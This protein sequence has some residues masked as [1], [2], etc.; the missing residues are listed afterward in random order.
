[1]TGR[2]DERGGGGAERPSGWRGRLGCLAAVVVPLTLVVGIAWAFL[3]PMG[4]VPGW[5][6]TTTWVAKSDAAEAAPEDAADRTWLAGD[7]VVRGRPDG[8]RAFHAGSGAKHWEYTPPRLTD[9][10]ALSATADDSVALIAYTA[11]DG[12]CA[13]V[14][15]LDLTDGRELWHASRAPALDAVTDQGLLPGQGPLTGRGFLGVGGALALADG[16]GLVLEGGDAPALRALELRTG[17]PRWTAAVPKGCEPGP[18]ATA[19]EQ[20]LTVL[21][22]GDER[23]LAA[24]APTDG[25]VRWTV[26]LDA[27]RGVSAGTAVSVVSAEP[28]VLRVDGRDFLA[29]G[30]DGR[31]GPRIEP[32]DAPS[33]L[34]GADVAVSDGRLFALTKGGRWG[35][36]V[37][38][39]LTSG[40]ELW[41]ANLGGAGYT[42]GGLYAGNGRVMALRTSAKSGNILHVLDATT[43]EEEQ[44]VFRELASRAQELLPFGELLIAVHPGDDNRPLSAYER[45]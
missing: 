7:L 18:S 22:C 10:C 32:G 28:I 27:R 38:Y 44:R 34:D 41:Q 31:P 45:W 6:M 35:R 2:T 23:K 19:P 42:V 12:G 11:R 16:L 15:A 25:T 13:T 43:G 29:F 8:V 36:I 21:T 40:G 30:P 17:A 1:M 33:L 14:A 3:H 37:G 24:F 5:S 26:P 9:I 39:D 4:W 20:V